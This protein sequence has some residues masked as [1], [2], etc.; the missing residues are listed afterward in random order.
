MTQTPY[1]PKQ[2][3]LLD[4]VARCAIGDQQAFKTLYDETSPAILGSLVRLLRNRDEAEDCLQDAYFQ[5]WT[6][7]DQ[8]HA[9]KGHV[10]GWMVTIARYRAIDRIRKVRPH[11]DSE[12][13]ENLL[14]ETPNL[15]GDHKK[16]LACLEQLPAASAEMIIKS[17]VEGYSQS[18]LS[19]LNNTPL[20][21]VKSWLRRGL[22]AL[23]Q[24][25]HP[26]D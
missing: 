10:F 21:T 2:E 18:E 1:E 5:I 16:L 15:G 13:V 12:E 3:Q 17:Y 23:K 8:Y 24:C 26:H 20:G 22:A 14:S 6:H 19:K 9:G 4:L 11:V 25:L 7:A